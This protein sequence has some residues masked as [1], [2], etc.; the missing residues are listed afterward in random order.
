MIGV[1]SKSSFLVQDSLVQDSG[2]K[3]LKQ[4]HMLKKF[5][6]GTCVKSAEVFDSEISRKR[7]CSKKVTVASSYQ[8]KAL[9]QDPNNSRVSVLRAFNVIRRRTLDLCE[10][11]PELALF[12]PLNIG[13]GYVNPFSRETCTCCVLAGWSER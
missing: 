6:K 4:L 3:V 8:K 7:T 5:R 10:I 1:L 12:A 9:T 11:C 13:A 2:F